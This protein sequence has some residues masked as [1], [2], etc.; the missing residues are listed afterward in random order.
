MYK[1]ANQTLVVSLIVYDF[2]VHGKVTAGG[3]FGEIGVLCK[4]PQPFTIKTIELSQILRLDRTVLFDTIQES[5]EDATIIMQN[6]YQVHL[7][8]DNTA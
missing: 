2:Q 8:L 3:V 1:V 6:L 7:I 5:K 4:V